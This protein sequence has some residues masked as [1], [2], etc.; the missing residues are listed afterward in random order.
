MLTDSITNDIKHQF[1]YGNMVMKLIF[2]NLGVF[3]FFGIFYL[4]SFLIQNTVIYNLVLAKLETPASL[5]T[6]LYQ[7]WSVFTYMF[8]HTSFMHVL[9]NMLWLY[10]FG[11]IFVLHIGDKKVLPLYLLGGLSGAL[12]YI[13]AYNLIPVFR[14]GAESALMLGASASIFAI[15]FA[16]ATLNPEYEIGL[17]FIG[18]VKIKYIALV[19]L[20]LDIINI[21]YG[22]AGGY[23]AH[24]GG[25]L[26][27]FLYIRSLQGGFD[28]FGIFK[29]V[30]NLF[31]RKPK[32][33][34][35]YKNESYQKPAQKNIGKTEQQRVDEILDK[36][37]RSGYDSLSKEEKDFLFNYSKK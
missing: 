29:P 26:S 12:I 18:P 23:I 2:V 9:F 17:M 14:P 27:G 24:I 25:A 15:V 35:T 11:E 37:A 10:W 34:A 13:L 28:L 4:I 31:K 20:L 7:P 22:N 3:L 8:L 33:K 32:L 19:S 1:R 30:G 6:L 5:N 36:I 21:P 16:A